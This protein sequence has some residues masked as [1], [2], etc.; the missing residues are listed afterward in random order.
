MLGTN[1]K[2]LDK[3]MKEGYVTAK[4]SKFSVSGAPGTGKSSF[5]KLLYNEPSPEHHDSTSVVATHEARNLEIISSAVGDKYV[6]TKIDYTSLKEMITQGVKDGIRHH[7]LHVDEVKEH[8][9]SE[10]TPVDQPLELESCDHPTDHQEETADSDDSESSTTAGYDPL[11][12]QEIVNLL[13]HVEKSEKLYQSHWIYGVDT[14]GQAAFIDIAPALLRYHS[15]NILT[16]KLTERLDDKA[17]FFFSVKGN[18]IGKPVE[19]QIT[20]FQFLEASFRSLSSVNSPELPNIHITHFQEPYCIVLGT[21]LDKLLKTGESLE[22]KNEHLWATVEKF[23][24]VIKHRTTTNEVIFPVNT[25]GRGDTELEMATRIRNIICKYYIEAQIPIRWFIFQLELDL[26]HKSSK[27]SIVSKSKCLVI[28]KSL[29]MKCEDIEAAL[30]YYHDLTIFLYFPK[31]LPNVVFLHPQPIFDRLSDLISI[32]FADVVDQLEK[33]GIYLNKPRAHEELKVQGTFEET[34]LSLPNSHLS[35]GFSSDFSV[36]DFLKLMTSLFIFASLPEQGKYFIPTVLPTVD[37]TQA[38]KAPFIKVVD[39]LI[40][41]WDMKPLP[42]GLFPALMVNLLHYQGFPRFYLPHAEA[43]NEHLRYRNAITLSIDA[44]YILLV[45]SIYWMEVY[46]AGPSNRCFA[47]RTAIHAGIQAI[48]GS[49]H[50]MRGVQTVDENFYCK[51]CS[52]KCHFC[53]IDHTKNT[54]TCCVSPQ[55]TYIH[56][57]RQKP[58]FLVKGEL[59]YVHV[60]S[61]YVKEYPTSKKME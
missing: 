55:T 36:K 6:W 18:V 23:G 32:S 8:G 22:E 21:F 34:L 1:K 7:E 50:Y 11:V 40:L 29:Q 33:R 38:M 14:G 60:L 37:L 27:S 2:L 47:I 52:D 9:L 28:G 30:M 24:K 61:L 53:R 17:K 57:S 19:K 10:A 20:N 54:L 44:G 15:V 45:D 4:W 43:S 58:W 26:L 35:Q 49:F 42:K 39:P 16:H 13:P 41:S 46:Y 25:T 51:I 5:L 59:T 56:E 48:I 3:A 12:S 31:I